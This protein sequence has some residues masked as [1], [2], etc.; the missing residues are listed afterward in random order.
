MER[1]PNPISVGNPNL[2]EML[3]NGNLY[4]DKTKYI[5]NLISNKS[6]DNIFFLSRPRRFG[7]SLTI[8]TLEQIF[9][10][11]KELFKGLYIYDE[12][13][14]EE[15]PVI[16]LNMSLTPF[17]DLKGLMS[18]LYELQIYDIA[19]RYGIINCL[20][21]ASSPSV[22]LHTLIKALRDK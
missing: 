17:S 9:I 21:R 6:V 5:Y 2:R 15:Y 1:K 3:E 8:D 13:D 22:W 20:N 16:R 19:E 4:I 11:N 7:K 18:N 10:G 14:F 12:Y